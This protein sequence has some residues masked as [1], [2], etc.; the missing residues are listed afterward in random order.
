M[1]T[2]LTNLTRNKGNKK[3]NVK[4][5]NKKYQTKLSLYKGS[6]PK[7][8]QHCSLNKYKHYTQ[9]NYVLA[10]YKATYIIPYQQRYINPNTPSPIKIYMLNYPSNKSIYLALQTWYTSYT[11]EI[12]SSK[13]KRTQPQSSTTHITITKYIL[14]NYQ[15]KPNKKQKIP[16]QPLNNIISKTLPKNTYIHCNLTPKTNRRLPQNLNIKTKNK[17]A[18]SI[19]TCT[20]TEKSNSS[21][22]C[23]YPHQINTTIKSP[24]RPQSTCPGQKTHIITP[25]HENNKITQKKTTTHKNIQEINGFTNNTHTYNI[26]TSYGTQHHT[27]KTHINNTIQNNPQHKVANT[28]ITPNGPRPTGLGQKI[29]NIIQVGNITHTLQYITHPNYKISQPHPQYK[30]HSKHRPHTTKKPHLK[31]IIH[32]THRL[33]QQNKVHPKHKN[34]PK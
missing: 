18:K 15:N 16:S 28:T 26:N 27:S 1:K 20:N 14:Y 13:N 9:A 34:H 8:Y 3:K 33:N 21:T 7:T 29:G 17:S 5:N 6:L 22:P 11:R 30:P 25:P 24:E 31:Y 10:F 12:M 23:S 32:P 19:H 4:E 2:P